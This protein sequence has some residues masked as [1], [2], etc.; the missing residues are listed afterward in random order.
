MENTTA[1]RP[2]IGDDV[3]MDGI[4]TVI[5][6][7][8]VPCDQPEEPDGIYSIVDQYGET[9]K[10]ERSFGDDHWTIIVPGLS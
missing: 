7:A 5:E 6:I 3:I 10:V 1:T 4:D 2:E 8:D 9:H